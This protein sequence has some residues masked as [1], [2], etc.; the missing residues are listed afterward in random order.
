MNVLITGGYGF[1]GASV[2]ERFYKEGHRVYIIDNLSSGRRE[3]V[4]IPHKAYVLS[5]ED[6]A[7]V[8]VFRS[9]GFDV[10]IHLAAHTAA[11]SSL[12]EP[13]L[14]V[15]TNILGLVNMLNCSRLHGV[16]KFIFASSA[17]VYGETDQ[18]PAR[19]TATC[20]P[21][22]PYGTS[23][24]TG[25][26]YCEKWRELYNLD[27]LCLRFSNVYGPRQRTDGE[28]GV[29]SVF[30][31]QASANQ[32]LTVFGDGRQTRDFI[33][34]DDVADAIYRG[35]TSRASGVYNVSSG[36]ETSINEL[37]ETIRSFAAVPQVVHHERRNGDITRSCLDSSRLQ[38]EL[39]WT[40]RYTLQE[41]L[42]KTYEWLLRQEAA[43]SAEPAPARWQMP[44]WLAVFRPFAENAIAFSIV[45]TLWHHQ[46]GLFYESIFDYKLIYILLMALLYGTRQS[47]L[48]SLAVI[49][50]YVAD[51][52][53]NG[54]DWGSLLYDPE[55]L[56]VTAL[57][58]FFGLSVGYVTD[59]H[60]KELLFAKNELAV[61]QQRFRLL[62]DVYKDTRSVKEALQRQVLTSRDS[63][64]RIHSIIT[65]LESLEPEQ[66]VR[67]AIGVLE[68][69]METKQI[70]IYSVSRFGYLRLLLK[71][72]D[73]AFQLPRSQHLNEVPE[74]SAVVDKK[75]LWVNKKLSPGLPMYAAPIVHDNEAIALVCLYDQAFERFTLYHE[76]LF[77]IAVE[78]ISR[79]LARAFTYV[80][81]TEN[82]RF[83]E[84]TSVLQESA[85][86]EVLRS[87][88]QAKE[89]AQ[90]DFTLLS[91]QA[92]E[93]NLKDVA[94][95]TMRLMR[96]TDYLGILEGRLVLLLSNTG[97][98][99]ADA[100]AAR[101]KQNGI[102]TE[103]M[104][105]IAVYA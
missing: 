30:L 20:S 15:R 71:S 32:P 83:V 61:E 88:M 91:V 93:E 13:V 70:A 58:L 103:Q 41:G 85:F 100:A 87:K 57:Y 8:E 27:T 81:A 78:I 43:V 95:R 1:I 34:V 26:M 67:S 35:A 56:F 39:G 18:L 89:Q 14:D 21:M 104:G 72:N 38:L 2:A 19:E 101:L 3:H 102:T 16:K 17:A 12:D 31:R 4:T 90:A 79:S 75:R 55:S 59:K 42:V 5:V 50:L 74:L 9:V 36:V 52:V 46:S 33:Y 25:E 47:F 66:V 7:C 73:P 80:S 82:E 97:P 69:L 65:E 40:P 28:A 6:Q 94:E 98:K 24:L 29:I 23:K 53:Q 92:T 77:K 105:G 10:V 11:S 96:D 51:S 37:I 86:R 44:R 54:R 99:E 22:S 84:G 49:G 45:I 62:M 76:N 68:N 48:A 60:R 64:G 63:L